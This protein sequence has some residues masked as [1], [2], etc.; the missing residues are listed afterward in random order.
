MSEQTQQSPIPATTDAQGTEHHFQH[1]AEKTELEKWIQ[2]GL[3]KAKPYSNQLLMGV[4]GLVVLVIA[5]TFW[6]QSTGSART[7]QWEE[8]VEQ[9]VPDDYLQLAKEN[10]DSSVSSW[11]LLQAGRGYLQEGMRNAL[12]NREASD[13]RL[14]EAVEAFDALVKKADAPPKAREEALFGLATAKEVLSASDPG[15]AVQAYQK[16]IDDFPESRHV[17]WA[18]Q[19][20]QELNEDSTQQ[21]YAWFREQNPK[22]EDRPLPGDLLPQDNKPAEVGNLDLLDDSTMKLPPTGVGA[23]NTNTV[24]PE[25]EKT[26]KPEGQP[27]DAPKGFPP[28]DSPEKPAEKP[29]T[30]AASPENVTPETEKTGTEKPVKDEPA[31]EEKEEKPAAKPE[32]PATPAEQPAAEEPQADSSSKE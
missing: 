27:A 30:D 21:F 10:P 31:S 14:N 7:A 17:P 23:E 12:T 4:I 3:E 24:P 13:A 18:Q 9:R 19:R 1:E 5:F 15:E 25:S 28:A 20:V 26:D 32:Q 2:S 8:F 6:A 22:P 16:L 29:T 11:A